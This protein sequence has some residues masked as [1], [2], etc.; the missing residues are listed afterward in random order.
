MKQEKQQ[1]FESTKEVQVTILDFMIE[2]ICVV[3]VCMCAL[4]MKWRRVYFASDDRYD[5]YIVPQPTVLSKLAMEHSHRVEVG[6]RSRHTPHRVDARV[7][8]GDIEINFQNTCSGFLP[9]THIYRCAPR[10]ANS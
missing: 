2:L 1:V 6:E 5:A 10:R 9:N 3:C 4:H 8:V 7:E